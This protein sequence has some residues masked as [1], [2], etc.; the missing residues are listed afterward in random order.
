MGL[1]GSAIG[2]IGSIV[3]GIFSAKA[4]RKAV[5]NLNN[6]QKENQD[7]YDRRYNEDA[8]QRADAQALLQRTEDSIKERNRQA[9]GTAAVMGGSSEAVAATKQANNAA[10]ADAVANVTSLNEQRKDNIENSYLNQKD[11]INAQKRQVEWNRANNIAQAASGLAS[12]ASEISDPQK[13][14]DWLDNK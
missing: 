11:N 3:G 14:Q 10:I 2:A 5:D 7:W 6:A 8:T 13:L 4:A 12:A 9:A 1:I